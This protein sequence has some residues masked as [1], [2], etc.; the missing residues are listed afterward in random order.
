M[1]INRTSDVVGGS[2]N[3]IHMPSGLEVESARL[4]MP[5]DGGQHTSGLTRSGWR[6]KLDTIKSHSMNRISSV[7]HTVSDRVSSIAPVAQRQMDSMRSG[8]RGS[9][10]KAQTHLRTN[11]AKWAGAAVGAGFGVGLLG[12]LM[13]H[14]SQI[15]SAMPEVIV[16]N[17]AC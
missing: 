10:A 12:R 2:C 5:T 1:E 4:H 17:A 9:M 15:R 11:P 14:R 13:L 6:E 7:R 16:L 3:V 8:L